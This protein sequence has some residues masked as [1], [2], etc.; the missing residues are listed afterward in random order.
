MKILRNYQI[1]NQCKI[2]NTDGQLV[3]YQDTNDCDL[4]MKGRYAEIDGLFLALF[5]SSEFEISLM[6]DDKIYPADNELIIDFKEENGKSFLKA[7]YNKK[8]ILDIAYPT[9]EPM[10]TF[11]Y[12]EESEDADFGEWIFNIL[13]SDLRKSIL[14][15]AYKY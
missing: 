14:L 2:L 10:S 12:T 13:N 1:Y 4:E 9:P 7:I 5:K 11:Y 15:N 8:K 6:V 3:D